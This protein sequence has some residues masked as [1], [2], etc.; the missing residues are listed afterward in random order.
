MSRK[1]IPLFPPSTYPGSAA[2]LSLPSLPFISSTIASSCP[3][4]LRRRIYY[5]LFTLKWFS[6]KWEAKQKKEKIY[7]ILICSL[8]DLQQIVC[9]MKQTIILSNERLLHS[10]RKHRMAFMSMAQISYSYEYAKFKK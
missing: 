8:F 3:F 1:R 5:T 10:G 7:Y 4:V 6:I 2:D 9:K